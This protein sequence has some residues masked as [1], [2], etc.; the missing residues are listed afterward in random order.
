MTAQAGADWKGRETVGSDGEPTGTIERVYLD[1]RTG[2]P[3][4]AAVT[5]GLLSTHERLVPVRGARVGAVIELPYDKP[6]IEAAP[7]VDAPEGLSA[8]D[9]A[10][11]VRHYGA[12]TP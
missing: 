7:A 5:P 12:A 2:E 10:R 6:T 11:L 8:A 1:E 4:W 3:A 9:E